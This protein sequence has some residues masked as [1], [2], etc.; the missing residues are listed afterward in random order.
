MTEQINSVFRDGDWNISKDK[1]TEITTFSLIEGDAEI[2]ADWYNMT[3]KS[4]FVSIQSKYHQMELTQEHLDMLF[5]EAELTL[6]K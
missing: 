4:N 3:L 5:E 6:T 2:Y 1:D